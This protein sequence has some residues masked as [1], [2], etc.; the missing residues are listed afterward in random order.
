MNQD[1]DRFSREFYDSY[2]WPRW[3]RRLYILTIPFSFL[4]WFILL[5]VVA[6][7]HGFDDFGKW[8]RKMWQ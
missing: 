8:V 3:L 2:Y 1:L 7:L 5:I 6:F 4:V